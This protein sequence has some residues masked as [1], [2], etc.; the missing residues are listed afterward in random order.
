MLSSY[1]VSI[2]VLVV[3]LHASDLEH[4]TPFDILGNFLNYFSKYPWEMYAISINGNVDIESLRVGSLSTMS[5]DKRNIFLEKATEIIISLK[6]KYEK[7]YSKIK[8]SSAAN[9]SIR[10]CNIVDPLNVV[11]NLGYNISRQGLQT[12]L[13]ALAG[14]SQHFSILKTFIYPKDD[15]KKEY[16]PFSSGE[17]HTS[18]EISKFIVNF[19]PVSRSLYLS[20]DVIRADLR[21]HPLQ[22]GTIYTNGM[23]SD[24]EQTPADPL[25]GD[26]SGFDII[27]CVFSY[28]NPL[29]LC[30]QVNVNDSNLAEENNNFFCNSN[31]SVDLNLEQI[32]SSLSLECPSSAFEMTSTG[33]SGNL[34][35]SLQI[36][37]K[38]DSVESIS[39]EIDVSSSCCDP[40]GSTHGV[41]HSLNRFDTVGNLLSNP[42]IDIPS[43]SL[44]S[45]SSVLLSSDVSAPSE[46]SYAL[47]RNSDENTVLD[48]S[49]VNEK[50]KFDQSL[51]S[52]SS[53][54]SSKKKKRSSKSSKEIKSIGINSSSCSSS[55]WTTTSVPFNSMVLSGLIYVLSSVIVFISVYYL[56]KS[57]LLWN[58]NEFVDWFVN[59]FLETM[60]IKSIRFFS[61]PYFSFV[62][63]IYNCKKW[64]SIWMPSEVRNNLG[65]PIPIGWNPWHWVES[66]STLLL[67]CNDRS[68]WIHWTSSTALQKSF[69]TALPD[70]LFGI[71]SNSSDLKQLEICE[72]DVDISFQWYR[73]GVLLPNSDRGTFLLKNINSDHHTGTYSCLVFLARTYY[74]GFRSTIRVAGTIYFVYCLCSL[75]QFIDVN[76]R[77]SKSYESPPI[78]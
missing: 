29:S 71:Y 59:D 63:L 34:K 16:S 40:N 75:L 7:M 3:M 28:E 10:S 58:S 1:A 68:Q 51:L 41:D 24:N 53:S 14:G 20:T 60:G 36:L 47:C 65:E 9:F 55:Q 11:N 8:I 70:K 6:K 74:I 77:T 18:L 48:N 72:N 25:I 27:P 26:I 12:I 33:N 35:G 42:S 17:M 30:E 4:V 46:S 73:D 78:Y 67:D 21:F 61:V 37:G 66:N 38:S 32:R 13:N 62:G 45:V 69:P 44:G 56:Y 64:V 43:S 23:N 15:F 2:M 57:W 5:S 50:E 31:E 49:S 39:C 19:F 76:F 54:H 52:T 22:V